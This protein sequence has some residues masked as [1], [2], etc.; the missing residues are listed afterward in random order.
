MAWFTT[1]TLD[2]FGELELNNNREWFAKNKVRFEKHVKKPMEEFAAE[3][4]LRMKEIDPDLSMQPKDAVFRIYRDTRFSKDKTPY[5]TNAGLSVTRG[6]KT[7]LASGVY[8]HI[9]ARRMGIASG[10]YMMEPPEIAAVRSHIARNLDEFARLL[11]DPE[12]KSRFGTITGA[13]NKILPAELRD[14]AKCQPLLFNKQFYYWAEYDG[15]EAMRDDLA[16]FV[17]EHVRAAL[18]MNGFLAQACG[19]EP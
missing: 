15:S 18:P 14:A 2:F 19:I 9:D 3:M 10:R 16:E 4:I 17:M 13:K 12:F 6:A 7:H 11:E 8:F 5:K 1:E